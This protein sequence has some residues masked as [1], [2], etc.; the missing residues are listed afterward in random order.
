MIYYFSGTGNSEW[1]AK[2]LAK[3]TGDRAES[4]PDAVKCGEQINVM[5][6]DEFVLV[7]PIYAWRPP[8]IVLDFIKNVTVE[9]GAYVCGVCT[10]GDE[11]GHAMKLLGKKIPLDASWSLIMP[12]NYIPMFDTDEPALVKEKLL[13]AKERVTKIAKSIMARERVY[14]VCEG[15]LASVRTGI[16]GS[17]FNKL[18][19]SDKKFYAEDTCISCGIC[20]KRCPAEN[21]RM[22]DA[23][24][25]WQ[26]HCMMCLA[27]IHGCPV[28]AI[29]Y[30][31][32]CIYQLLP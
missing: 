10:C 23:R 25:V 21:I 31:N 27:C 7:F 24:P 29:Q 28:E 2:T 32:L 11:A 13:S 18:A 30:G 12:N 9:D 15:S 8:K 5:R 17:G 1:T 4:I 3:L 19:M 22:K 16:V 26:G 14:D 20:E 6:G